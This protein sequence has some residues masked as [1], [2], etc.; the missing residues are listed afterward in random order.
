MLWACILDL[1][2]YPPYIIQPYFYCQYFYVHSH[3][4][5]QWW[6]SLCVGIERDRYYSCRSAW[7]YNKECPILNDQNYNVTT[8][9]VESLRYTKIGCGFT[10][11]MYCNTTGSLLTAGIVAL[12][13]KM[14]VLGCCAIKSWLTGQIHNPVLRPRQLVEPLNELTNEG[15]PRDWTKSENPASRHSQPNGDCFP[16]GEIFTLQHTAWIFILNH[17]PR[18]SCF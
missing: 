10:V 3:K 8:W 13:V 18:I 6:I 4:S 7:I 12:Q 2:V 17:K 1:P 9:H 14:G 15:L 16:L 5:F 11:C